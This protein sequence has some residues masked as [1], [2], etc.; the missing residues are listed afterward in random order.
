MSRLTRE[1]PANRFRNRG[2]SQKDAASDVRETASGATINTAAIAGAQSDGGGDVAAA[3][4][5]IHA[6][7]AAAGLAIV[8]LPVSTLAPHPLNAKRRSAP[9]PGHPKWE[10]LVGS[11]RE[12]GRVVIPLLV[13]TRAAFLEHRPALVDRVPADAEHIAI[14]GHRRSAAARFVGLD[15]VPVIV[16]D[17]VMENGGDLV[18]MGLENSGRD[19]L[20]ILETAHQYA[21]FIDDGLSQPAIGEI[22]GVSQP[23]VSR[24]L[25]LL[26]LSPEAQAVVSTD[27]KAGT[28]G[29]VA[30]ETLARE[31]PIG[32]ARWEWQ[33]FIDDDSTSPERA[34]D[35]RTA[36]TYILEGT[37]AKRAVE[38]VR[39]ERRS[40]LVAAESGFELIEDP[41]ARFGA[42]FDRHQLLEVPAAG[43]GG[44]VAALD[45]DTRTLV[46]FRETIPESKPTDD[47]AASAE[48]VEQTGPA[49]QA[50][51][52]DEDS[53]LRAAAQRARRAAA[54]TSAAKGA[55]KDRLS[56]L[57]IQLTKS[58]VRTDAPRVWALAHS[59]LHVSDAS[60]ASEWQARFERETDP[61]AIQR[62]LWAVALAACETRASDKSR[63]WDQLD[64]TYFTC[65]SDTAEYTP[66]AWELARLS[67]LRSDVESIHGELTAENHAQDSTEAVGSPVD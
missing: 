25:A 44:V 9:Q 8:D 33:S 2:G 51:E 36:L 30:A 15:T 11:I 24:H 53:R 37:P 19:D 1:N 18:A 49:G 67:K 39:A 12:V 60:S 22:M 5:S 62:G 28:I 52:G 26:W 66:T 42:Q 47:R 34:D 14:Y 35:Q 59:W 23:T 54:A 16:D 17:S 7:A 58:R 21:N 57:L 48:P 40:R 3:L 63:P 61:K 10:E 38:R 41:R 45:A 46:Y 55:S 31:L 13:V 29:L 56:T 4:A 64:A 43:T 50:V 32:K 65:L 27:K 20:D 6:Q